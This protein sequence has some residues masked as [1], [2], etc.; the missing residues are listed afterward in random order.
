[1]HANLDAVFGESLPQHD[2]SALKRA[3][4]ER[5]RKGLRTDD[6]DNDNDNHSNGSDQEDDDPHADKLDKRS[7]VDI[8]QN[9]WK[10]ETV[11]YDWTGRLSACGAQ[12]PLVSVFVHRNKPGLLFVMDLDCART[13]VPQSTAAVID[14]L[15]SEL[16]KLRASPYTY[17]PDT[18]VCEFVRRR[19][20]LDDADVAAWKAELTSREH[21][22]LLNCKVMAFMGATRP[23]C[24]GCH[25]LAM[26]R[27]CVSPKSDRKGELLY[28]CPT[29]GPDMPCG[30]K[31]D[32]QA[33]VPNVCGGGELAKHRY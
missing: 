19:K 33:W 10:F 24:K 14:G 16:T 20:W 7:M 2:V 4:C 25:Q 28:F 22:L 3:L 12:Q 32:F 9:F 30:G 6:D 11:A 27:Q 15:A 29:A 17:K 23:V 1:V 13:N 18:L 31:T 26:V 8:L 21:R 5:T